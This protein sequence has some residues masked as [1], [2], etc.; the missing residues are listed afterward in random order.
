MKNQMFQAGMWVM[1]TQIPLGNQAG[2]EY[3]RITEFRPYYVHLA[4]EDEGEWCLNLTGKN[5]SF[6]A[7]NFREATADEVRKYFSDE[8]QSIRTVIA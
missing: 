8:I 7:G 2:A 6:R 1:P 3:D 4:M 5:G